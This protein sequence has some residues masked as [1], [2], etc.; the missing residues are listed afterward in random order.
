[1]LCVS[2]NFL[3]C[4]LNSRLIKDARAEANPAIDHAR[5]DARYCDS[6]VNCR[7]WRKGFQWLAYEFSAGKTVESRRAIW[8]FAAWGKLKSLVLTGAQ[9]H[10]RTARNSY[11]GCGY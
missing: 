11:D 2:K 7:N 4:F 8:T 10:E 5:F 1:M 3:F 9:L 6:S